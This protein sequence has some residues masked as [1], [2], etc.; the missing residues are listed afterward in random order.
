[1]NL[2]TLYAAAGRTKE[3][4]E[5]WQRAL[6]VNP[7]IEEAALNLARIRTPAEARMVVERYLKFNPGS[8]AARDL[9][10]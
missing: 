7:G 3:A 4:A 6:A 5:L 8:N 10:K 2:G 1:V 9:L